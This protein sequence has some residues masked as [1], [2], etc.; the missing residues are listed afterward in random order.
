MAAD[1]LVSPLG[2][3]YL[4]RLE[5]SYEGQ[6]IELANLLRAQKKREHYLLY[7]VIDISSH[8]SASKIQAHGDDRPVLSNFE[9]SLQHPISDGG[10]RFVL[11]VHQLEYASP[12]ILSLAELLDIDP[13]FIFTHF[14]N[15]PSLGVKSGKSRLRVCHWSDS[16]C[17]KF[18][19]STD[20][21]A[22]LML[23]EDA[24]SRARNGE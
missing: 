8:T 21:H 6:Y 16:P 9:R 12:Y 18:P 10:I 20:G 22:T 23:R 13:A 19:V 15:C 4:E 24:I 11:L 1:V 17:L 3:Q 2:Q 7:R 14:D 5:N